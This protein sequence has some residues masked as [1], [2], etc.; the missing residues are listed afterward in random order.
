M[1]DMTWVQAE[2]ER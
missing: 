2:A 1:S